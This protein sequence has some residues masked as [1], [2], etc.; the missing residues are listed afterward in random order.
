M[1]F[2]SRV[3]TVA[4]PGRLRASSVA[5]YNTAFFSGEPVPDLWL[6]SL[7][8]SGMRVSP[9]LAMKLSAFICGVTT[10]AYDLA[11][12]PLRAFK[13]RSDGGKDLIAG[14]SFAHPASIAGLIYKL[15]WQPNATQTSAEFFASLIA[16]WLMRNVSYSE[17]V[18][19]PQHGFLDQLLPRH[20]DR[21][22]PER[23]PNGRV[24]YRL[25]EAGGQPRYVTQDE[26]LVVRDLSMDGGVTVLSRVA[27][28]ADAIGTALA[29][30]RAAGKFFK[31]GMTAATVAT[32][33]GEMDDEAEESLHRSIS[34][35]AA[36]MENSFGLMLIPDD[37]K[38]SNLAIEPDKAQMMLAREWTVYETARMLRISP[39]KLMARGKSEGYASA[40]QDSID[41]V[42]NCLRPIAV[43]IQQSVQRDL[44]LAKDTYSFV[45]HLGELLKGDPTQ[46]GDFI[47]K[48][49][50]SRA[51]TPSEVRT[52]FLD[53]NADS[54]LDQLSEG[55]F[56]P[57]ASGA[58][59][60]A[61]TP[62]ASVA[63]AGGGYYGC[64][65]ARDSAERCLKRE[66]VA[67]E[68]MALKHASDVAGWHAALEDFYVDHAAFVAQTMRIPIAVARG[69]VAE[70]GTSLKEHGTI[71]MQGKAGE[72]WEFQEAHALGLLAY[73]LN[74]QAAWSNE[75]A[76]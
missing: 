1:G 43:L 72:S 10:I 33:T 5:D 52:T 2:L 7:A 58:T 23:L 75:R 17:I 8:A 39:R 34:R 38:I 9:D 48:L 71:M 41:H 14:S 69:F 13:A 62:G 12:L 53:L 35:Y 24:R 76:A 36:G 20:P 42:V 63:D 51:M 40:Y 73:R 60:P 4:A 25:T 70:H 3:S 37:V 47:Q 30:E 54:H 26:M 18:P 49:I 46:M 67:I 6:S 15:Q 16:Q 19:S 50:A 74:Q 64:M 31:S 61:T 28:G 57:G 32:Y 59:K 27:Y 65:L 56:R 68:K 44:V 22:T 45:F 29:A 21:V 55:D 66:R 11:T